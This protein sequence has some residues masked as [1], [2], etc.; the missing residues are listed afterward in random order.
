MEYNKDFDIWNQSKKRVNLQ[1]NIL[2]S[3]KE[4]WWC[5]LGLNIGSEHDGKGSR[6]ERPVV[7]V[8]KI[9]DHIGWALP[10]SSSLQNNKY[11][12][13]LGNTQAVLSQIRTIDSRRLVRKIKTLDN[14]T[15][16]LL[17]ERLVLILK[18]ET[19]LSG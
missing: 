1:R 10:I 16:N 13:N 17:I 12:F 11:R 19:P 14:P 3:E 8:K 6:F 5:Q 7:I 15:F 18:N 2:F 9:H 4:I